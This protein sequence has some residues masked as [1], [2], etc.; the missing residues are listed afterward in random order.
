[1]PW[2][3]ATYRAR[4]T[5]L[6]ALAIVTEVYGFSP[7]A[8]PL[9]SLLPQGQPG[10]LLLVSPDFVDVTITV[11]GAAT[12]ELAIPAAASLVGIGFRNQLNVFEV[13]AAGSIVAV[14][15]S[16]ALSLTVGAF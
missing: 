14:T 16:N 6:P 11:G 9:A 12:T 15:A 8:L 5:G 2:L 4:G 13:D 10:C 7:L 3:G 1:L